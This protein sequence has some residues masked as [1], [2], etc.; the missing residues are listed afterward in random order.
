[1]GRPPK[2]FPRLIL[3]VPG[4]LLTQ[5]LWNTTD[6]WDTTPLFLVLGYFR[7]LWLSRPRISGF[8]KCSFHYL[9]FKVKC[10]THPAYKEGSTYI[11]KLAVWNLQLNYNGYKY[12]F[13]YKNNVINPA[14]GMRVPRIARIHLCSQMYTFAKENRR[15]RGKMGTEK[16]V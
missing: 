11:C 13:C 12:P 16:E 6:I 2:G 7:G 14:K 15:K 8:F 1:M 4:F 5:W 3:P 10:K 9:K